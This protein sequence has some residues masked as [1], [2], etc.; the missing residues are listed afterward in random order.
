MKND[1]STR[2]QLQDAYNNMMTRIKTA[3]EEAEEAA[4]ALLKYIENARE[5][6]VELGELTRD[7]AEKLAAWLERDLQD[8]GQHLVSTGK[9]LGDWLQF[10]INLIEERLLDALLL[11]ADHTRME[12]QQFEQELKAGPAWNAGEITGPGTLVCSNCGATTRFHATG[13]IPACP[14]CGHTVYHRKTLRD[15][16]K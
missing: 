15:E 12:M 1:D 4:P 14:D 5:T 16:L 6:A 13:H 2:E 3:I 7:E 8:A 10:D 11:A 9:E